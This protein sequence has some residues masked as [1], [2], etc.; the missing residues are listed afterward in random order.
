MRSMTITIVKK[1]IISLFNEMSG[2]KFLY[3]YL[4]EIVNK[5]SNEVALVWIITIAIYHLA[6][7]MM[8]VVHQLIL[9][10][11]QL[12]IKLVTFSYSC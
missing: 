8:F 12:G 3:A 1:T 6:S 4:F 11:F 5:V 2:N 7:K 9:Y 10:V